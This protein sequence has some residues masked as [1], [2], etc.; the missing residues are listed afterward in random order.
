MLIGTSAHE[1]ELVL[2][3]LV[4]GGTNASR[5]KYATIVIDE[6]IRMGSIHFAFRVEIR[7]SGRQNPEPIS[8][9]LQFAVAALLAKHAKVIALDQQH[10]DE[11]A[12]KLAEIRPI[13]LYD[14]PRRNGSRTGGLRSTVDENRA[15]TAAPLGHQI[16][17]VAQPRD[18]D[19]GR[20]RGVHDGLTGP[21][22]DLD[23]VNSKGDTFAHVHTP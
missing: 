17:A 7:V 3:V 10:L 21:G 15:H 6:N 8:E 23:P 11:L 16:L 19:T 22:L 2:P 14:H 13:G 9:C 4:T 12:A 5:A 1:S 18:V 20:I